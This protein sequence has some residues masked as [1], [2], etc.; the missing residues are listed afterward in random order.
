MPGC[1]AGFF[2]LGPGN[3][4]IWFIKRYSAAKTSLRILPQVLSL[5]SPRSGPFSPEPGLKPEV[6]CWND[7]VYAL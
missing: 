3:T 7:G 6:E 2:Y 1:G 4:N 5:K